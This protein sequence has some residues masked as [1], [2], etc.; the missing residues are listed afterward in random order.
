V[1]SE[2]YVLIGR[3]K[4]TYGKDGAIRFTVYDDFQKDLKASSH[5]FVP[6][7]G[8]F[9]PFFFDKKVLPESIFRLNGIDSLE[10]TTDLVSQPF[11]LSKNQV[12]K[13]E[14]TK[15]QLQFEFLKGYVL[16]DQNGVKRGEFVDI[17]AFP[18]QE[19]G[20]LDSGNAIPL[21]ENLILDLNHDNRT[22]IMDIPEGLLNI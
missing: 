6:I 12:S 8:I 10:M 1:E 18:M 3:L 16:I 14:S 7:D 11:F 4:K 2:N 22:I 15:A 9:V 21:N 13:S 19:L 20:I 17:Q 5:F